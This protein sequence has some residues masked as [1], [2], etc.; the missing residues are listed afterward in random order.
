MKKFIGSLFI[1]ALMLMGLSLNVGS[2]YVHAQ[3]PGEANASAPSSY[4]PIVS[5]PGIDGGSLSTEE[6]LRALYYLAITVAALLAVY[7]IMM[8]G[9]KWMFSGIATQKEEAK[10]DIWGAIVGLLIVLVAVV[11]LQTININL[12]TLNVL[13]NAPSLNTIL[14]GK[15]PI[16]P[17]MDNNANYPITGPT[18]CPDTHELVIDSSGSM[19]VRSCRLKT[20]PGANFPVNPGE[21]IAT[22]RFQYVCMNPSNCVL[23][24][25]SGFS[26]DGAYTQCDALS[27]QLDDDP[28]RIGWGIC[29]YTITSP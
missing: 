19:V 23:P 2:S 26:K 11:V 13:G 6:Y 18:S 3:S 16:S 24:G 21:T 4:T 20:S 9:I 10:K 29:T 5:I 8:G 25:D 7:K 14:G 17:A 15:A 22:Q 1:S 27:G 28:S 12:T